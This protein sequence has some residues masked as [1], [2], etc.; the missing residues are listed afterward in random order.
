MHDVKIR[1]EINWRRSSRVILFD[2]ALD[3]EVQLPQNL[4]GE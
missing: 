4:S 3:V 1:K 2:L